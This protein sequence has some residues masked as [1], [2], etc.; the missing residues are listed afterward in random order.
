MSK[1]I[2]VVT[3]TQCVDPCEL[4]ISSKALNSSIMVL[5]LEPNLIYIILLARM[6]MPSLVSCNN[7]NLFIHCAINQT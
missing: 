4:L 5:R 3:L 7:A 1:L 2:C 6:L